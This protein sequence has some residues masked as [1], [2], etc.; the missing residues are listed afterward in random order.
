MTTS[1]A[2]TADVDHYEVVLSPKEI[3]TGRI[4]EAIKLE[5]DIPLGEK[6]TVKELLIDVLKAYGEHPQETILVIPDA[7]NKYT[8]VILRITKR[9]FQVRLASG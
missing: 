9:L 4:A 6:Q 5:S 1:Y 3:T 7:L 2:L 8:G